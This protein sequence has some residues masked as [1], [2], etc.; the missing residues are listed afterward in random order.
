MK[1]TKKLNKIE[2]L[3]D[4]L[5]EEALIIGNYIDYNALKTNDK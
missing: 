1:L 2:K 3:I 5:Q 4:N